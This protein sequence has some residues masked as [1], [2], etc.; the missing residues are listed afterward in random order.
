MLTAANFRLDTKRG[1]GSHVSYVHPG[2]KPVLIPHH[3]NAPPHG[4]R[5]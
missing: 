2:I 5:I 1:K 3:D 4:K